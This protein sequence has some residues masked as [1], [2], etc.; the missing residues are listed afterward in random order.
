MKDYTNYDYQALVDRMTEILKDKEG[1][2]DAYQSS[3]GQTLIQLMADVT[4]HLHYMLE[5][6]TLE[7]FL[8]SAKLRTS[9]VARA[10]EL[11]YRPDRIKSHTGTLEVTI[12]DNSG[13]VSTV[14][15]EV[16]LAAMKK[17]MYDGRTFY[18][19][20]PSSIRQGESKATLRVKEGSLKIKTFDLAAGEEPVFPEYDN[21]EED[22]FF[23]YNNGEEFFDVRKT[24]D[25]NKRALAFLRSDEAFYDIKYGVEG[26]RIVFGEIG[27]A[28]V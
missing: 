27:R 9:V 14:A 22:V 2:G 12:L 24:D 10:S 8:E 1:W 7:S 4:D 23:V 21:I 3:T 26:M 16:N 28:H 11:G 19:T 6:R 5:R 25:V 18:V 17:I 20:A 13:S 15:G